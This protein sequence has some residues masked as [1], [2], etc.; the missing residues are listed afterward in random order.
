M[1]ATDG[2]LRRHWHAVINE[3]RRQTVREC[4]DNDYHRSIV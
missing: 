1:S 3:R 4:P 2:I